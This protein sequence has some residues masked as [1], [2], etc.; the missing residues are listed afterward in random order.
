[1][2]F[3]LENMSRADLEKLRV[4]V[5]K[6]IKTVDVRELQKAREAAERAAAEHGFTLAELTGTSKTRK[7]SGPVK[8]KYRNPEDA[9]QTWSGR[10][11]KPQWIKDAEEAGV[12]IETLAI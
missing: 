5:D 6:A 4:A 11:R 3:D 10:G 12:D 7:S 2:Q 9:T 8:A 1:M